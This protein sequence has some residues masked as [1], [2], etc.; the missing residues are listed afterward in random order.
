[1]IRVNREKLNNLLVSIFL[2]QSIICSII[3]QFISIEN[4]SIVILM[5][6]FVL[7]LMNN[8]SFKKS[9][10]GGNLFVYTVFLSGI[11]ISIFVNSGNYAFNYFLYFISFGTVALY[12]SFFE[13]SQINIIKNIV[14]IYFFYDIFYFCFIRKDMLGSGLDYFT[15]QMGVAYASTIVIYASVVILMYQDLFEI[16]KKLLFIC[17]IDI[18][19]AFYIILFDCRTRGAI[20]SLVVGV[21]L[22][23]ISTLKI[24]KKFFVILSGIIVVV[25]AVLNFENIVWFMNEILSGFGI[26]I[27][28]LD[29]LK[30]YLS[31]N[32]DISNGRS[33]LYSIAI[34]CI[35]D[36]PIIGHGV[37]Y[38]E[39]LA[40]GS[41]VHNLFLEILCEF[42]LIGLAVIVFKLC[43][44]LYRIFLENKRNENL[45]LFILVDYAVLML[46]FSSTLWVV[47]QFWFLM[48]FKSDKRNL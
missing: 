6:I 14:Y 20:F 29:K 32:M 5:I 8:K 12:I 1:M 26:T 19:I 25:F 23:F 3:D 27:G 44:I 48:F 47:P 2:C 11:V 45:L 38:F 42:G 28:I 7:G 43:S 15:W 36:S 17:C 37:G 9:R 22:I 16:D 41:Y 24:S 39:N 13:V 40:D 30:Y 46:S 33:G 34:K 31:N 21:A 35:K 18:L 10:I 4:I